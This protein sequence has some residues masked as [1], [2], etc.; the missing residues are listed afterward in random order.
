MDLK[1]FVSA[2]IAQIVQGVV[3]AQ[4]QAEEVGACV[5]PQDEKAS[6]V[7]NP[8]KP[9]SRFVQIPGKGNYFNEIQYLE[10]DVAVTASAGTET[11]GGIGIANIVTLGM[12][13]TSD[14]SSES[15]SRIK[16]RVPVVFPHHPPEIPQQK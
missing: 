13:G 4:K 3:E 1:E 10:F 8:L 14:K 15:V 11:K 16:F 5:N 2:T 9:G 12:I 6:I 7:S